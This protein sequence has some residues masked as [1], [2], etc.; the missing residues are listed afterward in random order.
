MR[1][2][3]VA[4]LLSFMSL[5]AFAQYFTANPLLAVRPDVVSAQVYNPYYEP[6]L[7]EGY[8]YG[9]T[10]WGNTF[11]AAFRD[12][13]PPGSYRFAYVRTNAWNNAFVSGSAQIYCRFF[14]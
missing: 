2:F 3:V 8:A 9:F 5:P 12:V 11:H 14:R 10:S 4:G 7:C 6:I 13:L 1:R